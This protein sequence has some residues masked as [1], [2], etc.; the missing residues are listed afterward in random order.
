MTGT[1]FDQVP[2]ALKAEVVVRGLDG[3]VAAGLGGA[4]DDSRMASFLS[5]RRW[6]GQPLGHLTLAYSSQVLPGF[7]SAS[8]GLP[9]NYPLVQPGA[10]NGPLGRGVA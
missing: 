10:Y 8:L 5:P 2:L 9:P 3:R 4:L 6:R 7:P 1:R